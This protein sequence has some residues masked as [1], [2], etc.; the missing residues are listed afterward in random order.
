MKA[1]Q[2]LFAPFKR[3][4]NHYDGVRPMQIYLLRL[5]FCL[6]FIFVGMDSWSKIISQK[7]VWDPLNA[8][9]YSVW[10]AYSVLS[11]L[12]ILN[13]LKMLPI[14]IFQIF[15]K[16]IWLIMVAYP[17]WAGGTLIAS[18]AYGMT[19]AFMWVLLPIIAMPWGYFFKTIVR[20]VNGNTLG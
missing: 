18:P 7:E 19:I 9:A 14:I 6:T 12:G 20:Q 17:L 8:V 2:I 15:Y 10:G 4:E 3:N 5:V 16:V 1:Y 11:L 13:P